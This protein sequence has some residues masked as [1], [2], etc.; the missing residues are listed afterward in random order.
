M[1]IAPGYR[2]E[3]VASEP[4]VFDPVAIAFDESSRL[5]ANE[6]CDYSEQETEH[7]GNVRLLEDRDRNGSYETSILFAEKLSWPTAI[8]CYD[9]GVFVGAAPDIWYLKDTNGDG[10]ADI[11]EKV[12]SGFGR[13]NVQG[14]MNS[15][16]WGLDNR[17][18]GQTSSSG[19]TITRPDVADSKPVSLGGRDF[20]FDPRTRDIRSESGGGQHGMSF[21]DWGNRFSCQNSD[22][23]QLHVYD[24]RYQK[25]DNLLPLPSIR[26]SIAIDGPQ[27]T[28]YRRSEVEPWRILRTNLR[29]TKQVPGLVEG[30]GRPSGYFTSATGVTIYRGDAMPELRGLAFVGDVGSNIVHRKRLKPNGVSMVGER[31]DQD[32]EFIAATDIWF[33]PVQFSNAPDGSLFLLDLYREVIEHPKSLPEVI[34]KHLDLTSG[35]DRGRLYRIIPDKGLAT[36]DTDLKKRSTDELIELLGH[37]NSWHRETTAQLLV[38]QISEENK[39]SPTDASLWLQ[40]IDAAASRIQQGEGKLQCLG[41]LSYFRHLPASPSVWLNHE[42]PRVRSYAVRLLEP[43]AKEDASL[44]SEIRKLASDGNSRVRFQVALTLAALPPINAEQQEQSIAVKSLLMSTNND[45]SLESAAANASR[46]FLVDFSN[47]IIASG[48]GQGGQGEGQGGKSS[49]W[50]ESASLLVGRCF[51]LAASE[52]QIQAID[53]RLAFSPNASTAVA[54]WVKGCLR[55][56]ATR[57]KYD[58]KKLESCPQLAKVVLQSI[59]QSKQASIAEQLS[60]SQKLDSIQSI[61]WSR[62]NES[63][64]LLFRWMDL[65]EPSDVQLA[66]LDG[67]AS[68]ANEEVIN[69]L[70]T[71]YTSLSPSIRTKA[72]DLLLSK[73]GWLEILLRRAGEGGFDL[74]DLDASRQNALQQHADSAI[75][76]KANSLLGR[77]TNSNREEV[78]AKYRA[79]LSLRGNQEI[80][81]QH[82]A[83]SCAACHRLDGVGYELGPNL[84]T[85]KYRGAEAILQNVIDPNREVNPQYISY[86]IL[87]TDERTITGM[88]ESETA[89]QITLVRGDNARDT[90]P[91][92]EIEQL[93]SSRVSIMPEGLENQL[94]PQAMA[95]LLAYLLNTP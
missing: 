5:Y 4:H 28:V 2:I 70:I 16:C 84:A 49:S 80:G 86:T 12:F 75:R 9:G 60:V 32:S 66:A 58:L 64:D 92:S 81:K 15:F 68:Y 83:K 44:R 78:L 82:F 42:D 7:L 62:S 21:D 74:R 18:Y 56:L 46:P 8:A 39:T 29:V 38:K 73:K 63:A 87:T 54:S 93:K 35:R 45:P 48:A 88:I 69:T 13:S 37:S 19:G 10:A 94:N 1:K 26:Q 47:E 30:G 90:I 41:V 65:R 25:P 52:A 51:A 14:L 61:R 20:S 31:I 11:R 57:W 43:M 3:L 55:G 53:K 50:S 91:R 24:E 89:T 72:A 40:K 67:I 77:S 95:D 71:K 33:R 79:S 36:R 17:L 76:E 59:E 34:K 27:A 23:L 6:M 85:F 22:H